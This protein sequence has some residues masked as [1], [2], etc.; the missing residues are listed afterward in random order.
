MVNARTNP[1]EHKLM[2]KEAVLRNGFV[3]MAAALAFWSHVS[4]A[5]KGPNRHVPRPP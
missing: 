4:G 2:Q 3:T 1:D 5:L